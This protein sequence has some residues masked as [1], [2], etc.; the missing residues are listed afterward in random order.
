MP[1]LELF[2]VGASYFALRF[3]FLNMSR[4]YRCRTMVC[5]QESCRIPGQVVGLFASLGYVSVGPISR[6]HTHIF[7]GG[8]PRCPSTTAHQ[9]TS[10]T[11]GGNAYRKT[12]DSRRKMSRG[13][14]RWTR[15]WSTKVRQ[16]CG[17]FVLYSVWRTLFRRADTSDQA[18]VTLMRSRSY[19]RIRNQSTR[20]RYG[21]PRRAAGESR[22][23]WS[24]L[25]H[26]L[27]HDALTTQDRS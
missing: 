3:D 5:A 22:Q 10:W 15:Q 13:Y 24:V 9:S 8:S 17:T 18:A 6:C 12:A 1:K 19:P 11:S 20:R 27:A 26:I 7:A 23:R 16:V 4:T 2:V 14:R 25:N 21:C